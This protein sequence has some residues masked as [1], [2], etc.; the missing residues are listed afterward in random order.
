MADMTSNRAANKENFPPSG[1]FNF[2]I[3]N[4][5]FEITYVQTFS[6]Q[7]HTAIYLCTLWGLRTFAAWVEKRNKHKPQ[8]KCPENVLMT[9][10]K[11][12]FAYWLGRFV[13]VA[14][15]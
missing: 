13:M 14:R 2:K 11:A 6:T 1:R 10:N 15:R 9:E 5:D 8:E 12:T 3:G 4:D 7:E